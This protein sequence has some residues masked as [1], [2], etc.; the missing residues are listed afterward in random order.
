MTFV[1]GLTGSIGMGKS[2]TSAMFA[3][4]GIPVWDADAAVHR[5]YAAG[6]EAVPAIQALDIDVI[7]NSA[8]DRDKL[9]DAIRAD[10]GLLSRVEAI[11]HPLVAKD[12]SDFI[13]NT[14][15]ELV[16]LDIPLLFE[17][18]A[19]AI[20]D[21]VVVVTAPSDIQRERVM[22][23]QEMTEDMFQSILERQMP[24]E[25]K[26]R[27]ADYVIDTSQGFDAARAQVGNVIAK[28]RESYGS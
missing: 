13:E 12:R 7:T 22:S 23:R 26:R 18:G 5:L 4:E 8:V 11:V 3:D 10:A 20:C 9:K 6:G 1:L 2:T 15:A 19:D 27:R 16:L 25:E 14:D 28:V 24:D 17:V 21:A